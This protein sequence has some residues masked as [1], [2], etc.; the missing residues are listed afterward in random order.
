MNGRGYVLVEVI[1]A[2]VLLSLAGTGLYAG[3]ME[4][5]RA[6]RTI[7]EIRRETDQ[8]RTELRTVRYWIKN[9][10]VR[11]FEQELSNR[12]VKELAEERVVLPGID[13]L[14]FEFAYLDT[15]E[16]LFFKPFWL[17]EPYFGI[18]KG[19]EVHLTFRGKKFSKLISIPQGRWGRME[20]C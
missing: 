8:K 6:E 20:C 1:V 12:L 18:P 14:R 7:H 16:N 10:A 4:G 2:G 3:L 11:R 15:D 5:L 9:H 13:D 17:D 19:I